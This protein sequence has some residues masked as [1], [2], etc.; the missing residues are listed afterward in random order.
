MVPRP[1]LSRVAPFAL[2]GAAAVALT[3]ALPRAAAAPAPVPPDEQGVTDGGRL[4][5]RDC[6]FCHGARGEGTDRGVSLQGI[7]AAE[8]DYTLSTGRMPKAEPDDKRRRQKPRYTR[9]Q[10][11]ALV[12]YLEPTIAGG[13]AIPSVDARA[14]AGATDLANGGELYRAQCASC[15]QWAGEGGGLLD[16]NAPSLHDATPRQIGDAVRSGPATM[17]AFSAATI[18]A[19]DLDDIA[20][21]VVYLRHPKDR[22]GLGLWHFGP[23]AEGL[24]AWAVGMV[25]I[26]LAL[27]WI[28]EREPKEPK[29]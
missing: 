7:G 28:G 22:G 3:L 18:S 13:P 17:P 4:Y 11:D 8:V 24:I 14:A 12:A 21:Y 10:I 9:A 1:V 16:R 20:A 29:P 2:L 26:A 15:H 23:V 25:V 27:H 6:A 5:Q 19:T